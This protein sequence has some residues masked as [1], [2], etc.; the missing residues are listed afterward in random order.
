V[1]NYAEIRAALMCSKDGC[2][3][4]R[5]PNV[6]C[7]CPNHARGDRNPSLTLHERN[8]KVLVNCKASVPGDQK[9]IPALI[10]RGLWEGADDENW[11]PRGPSIAEY[12]Y[13]DEN[14][15]LLFTVCRTTNKEFPSWTPDAT[16][17]HGKGWSLKG[18]RRVLFQLPLLIEAISRGR[19]VFLVEGEK[20]VLAVIKAGG[21]AVCNP[22]GAGKW[23]QDYSASLTGAHVSIVADNDPAGVAHAGVVMGHL[24]GIAASVLLLSPAHGKDA[25]DHLEAGFKLHEFRALGAVPEVEPVQ[26]RRSAIGVSVSEWRDPLSGD[27]V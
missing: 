23:S 22:G 7:P 16:K 3:C 18:V 27:E 25:Y 15:E 21:V 19:Q 10:E 1:S 17:P 2:P 11:T 4:Q 14:G 13:L 9:V 24:T 8:G 20:D 12:E 5:G 26:R 6:H